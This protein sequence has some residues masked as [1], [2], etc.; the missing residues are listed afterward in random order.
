MAF[1]LRQ[2]INALVGRTSG[3]PELSNESRKAFIAMDTMIMTQL[4]HKG[5][6]TSEKRLYEAIRPWQEKMLGGEMEES[7]LGIE[8]VEED[9]NVLAEG[10]EGPS[11]GGEMDLHPGNAVG[12]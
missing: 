10:E 12:V 8:R 5:F 4:K 11:T 1:Q 9:R 6:K 7:G 2:T 3:Q